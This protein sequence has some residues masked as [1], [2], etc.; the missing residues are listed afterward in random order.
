MIILD[1][2]VDIGV[3]LVRTSA[4][5]AN[6][7]IDYIFLAP[8]P[9]LELT[10]SGLSASDFFLISGREAYIVQASGTQ[11]NL[12]GKPATVGRDPLELLPNKVNILFSLLGGDGEANTITRTLTYVYTDIIPRYAIA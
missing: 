5:A 9:L 8:R 12:T 2:Q 11:Y 4:G 3:V 6:V 7:T 1:D 10:Y